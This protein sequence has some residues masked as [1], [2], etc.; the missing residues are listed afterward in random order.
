M[1]DLIFSDPRTP[2]EKEAYRVFMASLD[3]QVWVETVSAIL[4]DQ[5]LMD[6]VKFGVPEDEYDIEAKTICHLMYDTERHSL[7]EIVRD[8]FYRWFGDM[9]DDINEEEYKIVAM[10][11][12]EAVI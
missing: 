11:I 4:Y 6:L 7:A 5:D 9:A 8:E 12:F 10:R 1:S 2:E 3:N